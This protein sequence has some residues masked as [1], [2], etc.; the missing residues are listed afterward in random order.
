MRG[1]RRSRMPRCAAAACLIASVFTVAPVLAQET[2]TVDAAAVART[3]PATF[4][5]INYVGFWDAAQ[6]SDA[7]RVALGRTSIKTIR[8]PGGDPG[9]WYDWQCPFFTDDAAN[10]CPNA[11]TGASWS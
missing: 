3:L 5:G 7:S 4:H 2:V 1:P 9:D 6:G 10:P 8:F 11:P